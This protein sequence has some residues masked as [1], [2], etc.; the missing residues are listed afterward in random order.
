MIGL[1]THLS[2]RLARSTPARRV[3]AALGD[4]RGEGVIS[5][6]IAVLI[7]A[8]L[9]A[10]MWVGFDAIWGDAETNIGDQVDQIGR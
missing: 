1:L 6:A 3:A 10:A 7:M 5:A 8:F 9:G 2:I 4:D